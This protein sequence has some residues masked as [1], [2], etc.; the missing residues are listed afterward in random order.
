MFVGNSCRLFTLAVGL[1]MKLEF[2]ERDSD[3]HEMA[4]LS[5]DLPPS[6]EWLLEG[7]SALRMV[8]RDG[9]D[10]CTLQ[11]VTSKPQGELPP[12]AQSPL[13]RQVAGSLGVLANRLN[14]FS[15]GEVRAL[16]ILATTGEKGVTPRRLAQR[17]GGLFYEPSR[18][19]ISAL[20]AAL[21]CN[22]GAIGLPNLLRRHCDGALSIQK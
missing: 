18:S 22:L 1:V 2:I 10:Q 5:R 8:E 7:V 21:A 4:S 9:P 14:N 16:A 3:G 15:D 17:L 6:Q 12:S 20:V 11:I 19:D 13:R